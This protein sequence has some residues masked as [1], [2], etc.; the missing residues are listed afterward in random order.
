MLHKVVKMPGTIVSYNSELYRCHGEGVHYFDAIPRR[1]MWY[2]RRGEERPLPYD[3]A[4]LLCWVYF[5]AN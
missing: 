3:Y 5:S 4:H 1:V 2:V